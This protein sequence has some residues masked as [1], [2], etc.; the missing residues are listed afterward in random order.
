MTRT[1]KIRILKRH[2]QTGGKVLRAGGKN[3]SH[4]S[5]GDGG[6]GG[7]LDGLNLKSKK[8]DLM[9]KTPGGEPEL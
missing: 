8:R 3:C 6:E 2:Q 1:T 4:G 7:S 5:W 9:S